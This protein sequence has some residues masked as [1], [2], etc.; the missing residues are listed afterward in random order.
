MAEERELRARWQVLAHDRA[1]TPLEEGLREHPQPLTRRLGGLAL[2]WARSAL[3][4]AVDVGGVAR[5][6]GRQLAE[7][8][9]AHK[10]GER[11][12]L[13]ELVLHRRARQDD[14][15]RAAEALEAVDRLVAARRLETV[16]L[17]ADEQT[18]RRGRERIDVGAHGL[19]R[20]D[21]QLLR[22]ALAEVAHCLR[23]RLRCRRQH[24]AP[25]ALRQPALDLGGPILAQRRRA[26]DHALLADGSAVGTGT[27]EG[28]DEAERLKRLPE[29]GRVGEDAPGERPPGGAARSPRRAV[30]HEAHALDLPREH[31]PRELA[32]D[33]DGFGRRLIPH[34]QDQLPHDGLDYGR[35]RSRAAARCARRGRSRPVSRAAVEGPQGLVNGRVGTGRPGGGALEAE[36]R[37]GGAVASTRGWVADGC[38]PER[39]APM[40]A[41]YFPKR[42]ELPGSTAASSFGCRARR[43]IFS[44]AS[45]WSV[46]R[47]P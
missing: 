44:P 22:R 40:V 26:D 17:V 42:S 46:A 36:V 5:V 32:L 7:L 43:E 15:P 13:L 24:L 31:R 33:G 16:A 1:V 37:D 38:A 45:S 47:P 30:V 18:D 20:A 25:E 11:P 12:E 27:Q 21:Q 19:V 2:R 35:R 39:S 3:A 8:A 9:R 14:P 41:S 10:V 4:A 28:E 6:E 34:V 23:G 29:A